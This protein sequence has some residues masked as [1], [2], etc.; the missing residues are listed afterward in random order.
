[1][2]QKGFEM[3]M[4]LKIALALILLFA[5]GILI[6]VIWGGEISDLLNN[7]LKVIG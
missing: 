4:L 1:M 2:N 5:A 7:F 6:A 3:S